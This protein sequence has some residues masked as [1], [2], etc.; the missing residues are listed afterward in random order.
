[1]PSHT[2]Q[3][4]LT[5]QSDVKLD[6]AADAGGVQI[7]TDDIALVAELL[8]GAA[9][10]LGQFRDALMEPGLASLLYL[11]QTA[12]F[13]TAAKGALDDAA[14]Q[15]A[16]VADNTVKIA[17]LFVQVDALYHGGVSKVAWEQFLE[18][19]ITDPDKPLAFLDP[20][21][22]IINHKVGPAS[23]K[24]ANDVRGAIDSYRALVTFREAVVVAGLN[25]TIGLAVRGGATKSKRQAA[26][27]A[28]ARALGVRPNGHV[29]GDVVREFIE[30][31]R[32]G[33]IDELIAR[34]SAQNGRSV[35]AA[36]VNQMRATL[37]ASAPRFGRR[38]AVV[39]AALADRSTLAAARAAG[40]VGR[41]PGVAASRA[42]VASKVSA[43][44]DAKVAGHAVGGLA[45]GA[46]RKSLVVV[47]VV[48]IP[49]DVRNA[50]VA[51]TKLGKAAAATSAGS[52]GLAL[53]GTASAA[54]I[55]SAPAAP[56]L[57]LGS[58][59]LFVTSQALSFADSRNK[60]KQL[61]QQQ[62][63]F[64]A[65]YVKAYEEAYPAA[66]E[67]AMN[68][69]VDEQIQAANAKFGARRARLSS[70]PRATPTP[71][72]VQRM[73]ARASRARA[74]TGAAA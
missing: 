4:R 43:A 16:R 3:A 31:G 52:G 36:E 13:A 59:A 37:L 5:A 48:M 8:A 68:D 30:R 40:L 39:H 35:N 44:M 12:G 17:T 55:I 28:V 34:V 74:A 49:L 32:Y 53:A 22:S 57:F 2:N 38:A 41:V 21:E 63:E 62:K 67:Q 29:A 61:E 20:I 11:P 10:Q 42:A 1:M 50:F 24:D 70:A 19:Q 33:D 60:Q 56:F 72:S 45:K 9:A 73:A 65:A 66:L 18:A 47:D 25:R 46:A 69:R 7:D 71:V 26:R 54:G 58:G 64:E 14:R 51:D 23:F 6:A 27:R 15:L